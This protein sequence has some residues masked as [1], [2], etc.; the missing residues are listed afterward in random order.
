[1]QRPS[2][3]QDA[4]ILPLGDRETAIS[5]LKPTQMQ[6]LVKIIGLP[7]LSFFHT[8]AAQDIDTSFAKREMDY[9]TYIGLVGKNSLEYAAEK[10][11]VPIA[12]ANVLGAGVFPDP[13]LGFGFADNGERR[14]GMGYG[15]RSELSWTLELGGKRKARIAV[16]ENEATL[17]RLLLADYFRNLRA[18][19]TLAYLTAMLNRRL[20]DVLADSHRQ[21]EK[22][23]EADSVRLRLGS[24]AQV[25][26]RQSK[27]EA[28]KMLN[29][30]H[31]ARAELETSLA[32]LSLW[33]GRAQQDALPSPKEDLAGFD[34]DF[35]LP[36]LMATAQRNR[37]DLMAARQQQNVAQSALRLAKANRAIDLGLTVGLEHN[38]Y[39]RN[40]IAPTP[41]FTT[42]SAGI[43]I[44]IKFSNNRPGEF[45]AAQYGRMQAEQLYKHAELAVQTEVTQAFHRYQ[46]ARKQASQFGTDLLAEAKAVLDG[47]TYS[48]RRG[49][50]SLL[51]VLDARRTYNEVRQS[52]HQTL[53]D[54]AAA[55]V[56]LERAAG[57]W[58][59]NF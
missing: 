45:R 36:D 25:D 6:R 52:H 59:I 33:L 8:A 50:T 31:A 49:E 35:L 47:K 10:F 32:E 24:I 53:Y 27:L 16:A 13:E 55:L 43:S 5:P 38:S 37:S 57:I 18:D 48:Y 46:A 28:R 23:A 21:M 41:S 19:A 22:L 40:V 15:F 30:V 12:E 51:E 17:A 3:C 34:R 9:A 2:D 7:V 20:L 54:R 1:M 11:S 29:E 14:M 4:M 39:V 26:A 42:V 56:E 58:D 44:P